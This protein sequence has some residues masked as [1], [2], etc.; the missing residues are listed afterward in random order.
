M[1]NKMPIIFLL[2]LISIIIFCLVMFL[3]IYLSKGMDGMIS[4]GNVSENIILEKNLEMSNIEN[5]EINQD[6]GDVKFEESEDNNITVK[7]YGKDEKDAKAELRNNKLKIENIN[8]RKFALINLGTRK[9][10]IIV[11]LPKNYSKDINIKVNCGNA[12]LENTDNANIKVE[13]NAGN[14]KLKKA[15]NANIKCDLGDVKAEE[16]LNKCD[17]EVDCGNVKIEKLTLNEDSK[18]KLNLGDVKIEQINEIYIEADTD[19]G[20]TNIN[21][22]H[23]NSETTLKIKVDCGNIN[24]AK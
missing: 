22:N 9:S 7:I 11:Y 10:E 21:E 24:I 12:T 16:I 20:K 18:I 19:L 1:K 2:I 6:Y 5:I 17:I 4:I 3:V 15:K 23:R 14:V 8:R 13:C